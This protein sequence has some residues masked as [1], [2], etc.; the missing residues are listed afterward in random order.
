MDYWNRESQRLAGSCLCGADDVAKM[1]HG[2]RDAEALDWCGLLEPEAGQVS[3]YG[4]MQQQ[5]LPP[6]RQLVN[7]NTGVAACGDQRRLVLVGFFLFTLS[8]FLQFQFACLL[9][10]LLRFGELARLNRIQSALKSLRNEL[11]FK[12]VQ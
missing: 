3:Q 9:R 5:L 8:L 2:S 6:I 12:V 4:W 10:S 1:S 11:P 7:G